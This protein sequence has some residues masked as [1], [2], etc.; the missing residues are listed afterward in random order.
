MSEYNMGITAAAIRSA[1]RTAS[2][3]IPYE[4]AD[5]TLDQAERFIRESDHYWSMGHHERIKGVHRRAAQY[6]GADKAEHPWMSVPVETRRDVT[7]IVPQVYGYGSQRCAYCRS[8]VTGVE[9]S[10]CGA[11]R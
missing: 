5:M 10:G 4:G 7:G 11:R 6:I 3:S 8:A 1:K 2:T 9:C